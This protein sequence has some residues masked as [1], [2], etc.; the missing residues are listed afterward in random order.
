L[1]L[2]EAEASLASC[3]D[4]AL[5]Q[6]KG[7]GDYWA[8]SWLCRLSSIGCDERW[9]HA[10]MTISLVYV[11]ML[12]WRGT[13]SLDCPKSRLLTQHN[14]EITHHLALFLVRGWGLGTFHF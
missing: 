6:G 10:C 12:G 8:I 2:H 11:H 1:L 4:P 5:S 7:S 14:Q 13:V 3:P 9:L